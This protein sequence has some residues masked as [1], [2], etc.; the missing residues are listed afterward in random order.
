MEVKIHFH[1]DFLGLKV[2]QERPF[3]LSIEAMSSVVVGTS[4]GE[5]A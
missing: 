2:I 3:T 4:G 5:E 1:L